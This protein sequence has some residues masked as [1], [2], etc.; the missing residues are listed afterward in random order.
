VSWIYKLRQ[1]RLAMTGLPGTKAQH[2]AL[3]RCACGVDEPEAEALFE[4]VMRRQAEAYPPPPA[5]EPK[6]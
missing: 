6:G 1:A 3:I 4:E 2:V 5:A